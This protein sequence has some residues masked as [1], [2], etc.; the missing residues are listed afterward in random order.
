[1]ILCSKFSRFCLEQGLQ[2]Q[3]IT[4]AQQRA[5]LGRDSTTTKSLVD[6]AALRGSRVKK[7]GF[8]LFSFCENF[9]LHNSYST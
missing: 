7:A 3:A 6:S 4:H 2:M 5:I 8:E 9:D 1:M